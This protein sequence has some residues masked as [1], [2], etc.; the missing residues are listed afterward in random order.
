MAFTANEVE[1]AESYGAF[2]PLHIG[3]R[4][5]RI[6]HVTEAFGGGVAA[7]IGDYVSAA[8]DLEHWLLLSH[9][10]DFPVS[11]PKGASPAGV[12]HLP[13]GYRARRR[14]IADVY[15]RLRPDRV[16]VHSSLAGAYCRQLLTIPTDDIVYTPHCYAFERQDTPSLVRAAYWVAERLLSLRTGVVAAC[17]P[18]EAQ[19]ATRM[20]VSRVV[21]VP[22]IA[23][24]V[25]D[26]PLPSEGRRQRPL[27]VTVGRLCPQKDPAFFARA[28][29]AGPSLDWVWIGEGDRDLRRLLEGAGVRVTGWLERP[30]IHRLLSE[31]AVYVHTAA[32]EGAPLALLEAVGA[33]LPVAARDIPA[34]AALG[35]PDLTATP[36]AL[37][38]LAGHLAVP[39]KF[40]DRHLALLAEALLEHTSAV[41][42]ARLRQAYALGARS[43]CADG[44]VSDQAGGCECARADHGTG[45]LGGS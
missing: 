22:H 17:S 20:G 41:Q 16:H 40:R 4:T 25:S 3:A 36:I 27:A 5:G 8:P 6:L 21:H 23:L 44:S 31:A 19:L 32:W 11:L 43:A 10:P 30:E 28:A 29:A 24:P 33:G 18:R 38:E 34:L 39:G 15:D 45:P 9:R 42:A 12:F 35:L 2:P 13:D 1:A 14:A 37:A 7:A 26:A